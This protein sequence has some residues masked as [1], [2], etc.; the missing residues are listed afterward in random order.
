MECGPYDGAGSSRNLVMKTMQLGELG[1][2]FKQS[3]DYLN[4]IKAKVHNVRGRKMLQH[5]FK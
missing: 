5:T 4:Q 2:K 3:R 1:M